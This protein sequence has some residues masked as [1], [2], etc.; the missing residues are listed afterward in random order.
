MRKNLQQDIMAM[1]GDIVAS[2]RFDRAQTVPHHAKGE[3]IQTHSLETAGLALVIARLLERRG[4]M[5][6]ETD[7]VRASLLHDIGMTEERVSGRPSYV[8]AYSHP[9][10]GVRIA[11]E[12]FS[13]NKNQ[14]NAIAHHMWPICIVPPRTREG[15]TVLAADKLCSMAEAYKNVKKR[16]NRAIGN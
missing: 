4:I 14:V 8:K 15:W 12:E 16:I 9:R 7:V 11:R 5:M 10:E 3:N 6:N 13:A 2:D 1:G